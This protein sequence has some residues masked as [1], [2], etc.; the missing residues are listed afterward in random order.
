M[1]MPSGMHDDKIKEVM[2]LLEEQGDSSEAVEEEAKV[3]Q[4]REELL[5]ELIKNDEAFI[6]GNAAMAEFSIMMKQW[7]ALVED[8]ERREAEEEAEKQ[9]KEGSAD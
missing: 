5:E 9:A 6:A 8:Y 4:S 7:E 2:K 1:A 3:E